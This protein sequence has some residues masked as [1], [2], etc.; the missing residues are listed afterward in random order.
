MSKFLITS[1]NPS[2]PSPKKIDAVSS[3]KNS[4][5]NKLNSRS[6]QTAYSTNSINP[7][8][9]ENLLSTSRDSIVKIG[10]IN[11]LGSTN[12]LGSIGESGKR[13]SMVK[14]IVG[15]LDEQIVVVPYE[16]IKKEHVSGGGGYRY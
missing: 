1:P 14:D 5:N 15:N 7:Q 6:D 16:Q 2:K 11:E 9:S 8:E 10:S 12:E 13:D 4:A 3:I